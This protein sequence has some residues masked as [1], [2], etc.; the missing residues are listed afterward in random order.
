M[1]M[2]W[3][4]AVICTLLASAWA[5]TVGHSSGVQDGRSE[6]ANECRNAGAF[7]VKRTGFNC[8]VIK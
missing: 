8:E 3:I 4:A 7:T 5:A 6:V 2:P 1:N